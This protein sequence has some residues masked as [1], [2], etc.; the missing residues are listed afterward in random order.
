MKKGII[1]LSAA[2][3]AVACTSQPQ[4]SSNVQDA[5]CNDSFVGAWLVKSAK[6][7]STAEAADTVFINFDGNGCVNGCAGVN[8]FS[9]SYT[10]D[11]NN[12]SLQNV[13]VTR[14]MGPNIHIEDSVLSAINVISAI[15]VN[16][17]NA[18]AL[19]S[20]GIEVMTLVRK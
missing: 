6:G 5:A 14:M 12:V 11:G 18:V 9:G 13:G 15:N 3:V 8:S 1:A 2:A 10:A 17:D 16:G 4:A 7:I 20:T 19:D